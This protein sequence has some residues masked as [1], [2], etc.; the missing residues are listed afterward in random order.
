[1]ARMTLTDKST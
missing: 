1:M